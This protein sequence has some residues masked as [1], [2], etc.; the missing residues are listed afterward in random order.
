VSK[1]SVITSE[2][3][4]AERARRELARR[5]LVAFSEYVGAPFYKA[6]AHH[7]IVASKLEQVYRYIETKGQEGIGRLMIFEPPRHGK[8]EQVS[9]LF[10]AWLLGKLPDARV[11]LTAYGA[12]LASADSRAV[13]NYVMGERYRAIF[14]DLGTAEAPVELSSDSTAANAWDLAA[15]HRG[16]VVAAGIGG[17]ITGKGAHLLVIDDPFKNRDDAESE[18]YRKKAMSWYKSSAYTRLED[19]GA[20]VVTHT[21]WHP[22][23]LA[24]QLLSLM[25]T[26][27]LLADQWEVVFLPALALEEKEY[28]QNEAEFQR[29]LAR[30]LYL[31]QADPLGR[32]PGEALWPEKYPKA[33]LVKI[34]FNVGPYETAALYQQSPRPATGGFFDEANF[35][36]VNGA[37][38]GLSWVRY[39]DLALGKTQRADWNAT[40]AT[41][42]DESTGIIYYR[43]MLRVHEL[44]DFLTQAK[45]WMLSDAEN[46]VVWGV[47]DVN[48]QTLALRQFLKDKDLVAIPISPVSPDADKVSRARAVQTRSRQGLVRLV[49]GAWNQTFITEALS[50]PGGVHDDQIDTA[51][52][53]LQMIADGT[54]VNGAVPD[55][56]A[57]R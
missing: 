16:G 38:A 10:P 24:G 20:I 51:S 50:F 33:A 13:R 57:G 2:M 1:N 44:D 21:R 41:A 14:G 55:P 39:V 36:I 17:G 43:D 5:G 6:A 15:P 40:L 34:G 29:N 28:C 22:E 3:A 49:R 54:Y 8:S 56:F 12:D 42:L 25:A 37:P 26:D 4:K 48:F 46:G 9:R 31:P 18:P 11:I 52:G 32:K 30:G 53:G 45:S 7:R 19:G 27:P 47:E 23:D 35:E